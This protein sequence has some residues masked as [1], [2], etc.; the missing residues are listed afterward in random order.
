MFQFKKIIPL[1]TLA[2]FL[3]G[4]NGTT[5]TSLQTYTDPNF[6]INYIDGWIIQT[7]QDFPANIPSSTLVTFSEPEPQNNYQKTISIVSEVLPPQTTSLE[8]AQ[9]NINNAIQNIIA[10]EK[11]EEKDILLGTEKTKLI[12]FTGKSSLEA[13]TLKYIQTYAVK[14]TTGY[15]IT[16]SMLIDDDLT[17]LTNLEESVTSFQTKTEAKTTEK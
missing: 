13:K 4:C 14:E 8:Y 7:P 12:I 6:S 2:I 10:F 16:A 15:T 1:I 17:T 3:T 9:A 5:T 11:I